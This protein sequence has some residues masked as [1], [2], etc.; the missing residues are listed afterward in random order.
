MPALVIDSHYLRISRRL[1]FVAR[2]TTDMAASRSL[3][4]LV[5]STMTADDLRQH[6]FIAKR[7]GQTVCLRTSS[8]CRACPLCKMCAT[9]KAWLQERQGEAA[10]QWC[11]FSPSR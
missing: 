10:R 6:Y 9:G 2:R 4:R 8:G 11:G 7:H 5:P 1:G 3:L